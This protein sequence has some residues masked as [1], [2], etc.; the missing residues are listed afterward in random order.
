MTTSAP[1]VLELRAGALRLALRLDLG[2]AVAGLWRAGEPVLDSVEPEAL[3]LAR[4]SGGFVLAPYSNRLGHR[5]FRFDGQAHTTA[6]N[7]GGGPHSMHGV[8]FLR[9]WTVVAQTADAAD[10][11][12]R[13]EPDAH[14]PFAFQVRQRLALSPGSLRVDLTLTNTDARR[15]PAG[16]GWHPYFPK[17]AGS[18]LRIDVAGRWER[19][20]VLM[21][22]THR[23]PQAGIDSAVADLAFDH[24]FDG[25]RG[26]AHI[27]D[28]RHALRLSASEPYLVVF[29]PPT[30]PFFAVEPVSHVNNA[31]QMA[32]PAAHGLR[33]LAQGEAMGLAILLEIAGA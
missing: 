16:L 7:T 33:S 31:I 9:P 14:W 25:W 29:T 13:H 17:R 6:D 15:A 10:L 12:Y 27:D 21:L 23:V 26:V 2:A 22:P 18:R 30:L 11:A 3:V 1:A 8:A 24:G 5:R 32:D 28:E 19:D 4:R 20:D